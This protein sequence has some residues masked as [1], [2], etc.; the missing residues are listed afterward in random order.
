MKM[1]MQSI[2]G[3]RRA[4]SSGILFALASGCSPEKDSR[5]DSDSG[6]FVL[7]TPAAT[8][9]ETFE[10]ADLEDDVACSGSSNETAIIEQVFL[11]QT[12][13]MDPD[14]P[15][16]YLVADRPVLA[17]VFV[18]GVGSAPEIALTAH[19]AGTELGTLCLDGPATLS[20]DIDT[21]T[22]R[23]RGRFT[24]TIPADW[25]QP[26]FSISVAAGNDTLTYDADTLDVAHAPEVNLLMIMMDV[27][28]YNDGAVDIEPPDTFLPELASAMPATVTRFGRFPERVALPT[29]ALGGSA[30]PPGAGPFILEKRLCNDGETPATAPC[31]DTTEVGVWDVNAAA[32][33][34]IDAIMYAN[35]E[36]AS[37]FYYG[38]TGQLFPGGWGGGKTFVS[39]DYEWVTIHEMGHA[40]SLPHWGDV[41]VPEEIDDAWSYEY[42]WGGEDADG[43]GRGP[44]WSYIQHLDEFISPTCQEDWSDNFGLERSDAM[45][46]SRSCSEWRTDAAGPW[47]GFGDF[48]AYAMYRY[49]TGTAESERG[50]VIDPLSGEM[51]F[52][53]PT[54]AGF[55]VMQW[56]VDAPEYTRTNPEVSPQNWETFDFWVPAERDV[57][58]YTIYGS[59]HPGFPESNILYA[60]I[61]WQGTLPKVLDPTDPATFADLAAGWDGPYA[62][63]FWWP[64]DLTFRITYQDGTVL[65]ALY[66][67]GGTDREWE[68]GSG[69]WRWDLLY[70]ALNVPAHDVITEV[71]LLNRPMVVHDPDWI[72][73]GNI[74][75]P[76]FGI[77]A[78]NFMDEAVLLTQWNR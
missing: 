15:F 66:P 30:Q 27:L 20:E 40:A 8:S 55:P 45:Q 72:D 43:G 29:F 13:L 61:Y 9:W 6:D 50:T 19:V 68:V 10:F 57:P 58:V 33:R 3:L 32:L 77:T 46:R 5:E 52:N 25:V 26:D 51:D 34:M 42:P 74:A 76:T 31:T 48:S 12:H 47:D 67:Y 54:H 65:H 7:A 11:A 23:R 28:N 49:L 60:P 4:L 1:S 37:H 16:F 44:S 78:E 36:Y 73:E 62:D 71:Q 39:A 38:N 22:H 59:H 53:V 69:P 63:Y 14:W 35:G 64:K 24:V 70:F 18:T 21:E 17:E 2:H 41:F 75:N 56:G